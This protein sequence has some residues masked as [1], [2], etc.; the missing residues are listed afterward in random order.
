MSETA[1]EIDWLAMLL[2]ANRR[3]EQFVKFARDEINLIV[4]G[5]A[6]PKACAAIGDA[7][8]MYDMILRDMPL[9]ARLMENVHPRVSREE[10]FKQCQAIM[11][12]LTKHCPTWRFA[13]GSVYGGIHPHG[14]P[15]K[16]A[17]IIHFMQ[18]GNKPVLDVMVNEDA[19]TI[20]KTFY[21]DVSFI[22]Y[23]PFLHVPQ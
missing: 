11:M 20:L 1:V 18:M 3:G 14:N 5:G 16:S 9:R 22:D 15:D 13:P 10:Y 7:Y 19:A 4:E 17:D 2:R 8:M 23:R 21:N 6:G 12:I